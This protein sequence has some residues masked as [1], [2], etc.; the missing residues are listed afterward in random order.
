MVLETIWFAL[1]G[2]LWAIFF[3]TDGFDF[4]VGTLYPFLGKSEE[5]KRIMINFCTG[6][7]LWRCLRQYHQL[8]G[9][10]LVIGYLAFPLPGYCCVSFL[11]VYFSFLYQRH[12]PATP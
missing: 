7:S 4:G 9:Y 11:P 10:S 6:A 12:E 8:P 1:W 5:D 3:M 2:L